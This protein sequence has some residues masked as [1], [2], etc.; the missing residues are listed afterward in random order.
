MLKKVI[1]KNSAINALG[2]AVNYAVQLLLISYLVKNIGGEAYGV[3]VIALALIGNS[4]LLEAGF[5]LS[6]TKYTAECKAKG[7]AEGLDRV[8]NTGF[9]VNTVL[10][11]VFSAAILVVIVF[12]LGFF[13]KVPPEAL[14]AVRVLMLLLLGL[15]FFEFWTVGFI[16]V[17]EGLQNYGLA[18]VMENLKWGLRLIFTAV[19]FVFR[20]D[21]PALGMAYLAAGAV[22]FVV[23]FY[24][25]Y[26]P[27]TGIKFDLSKSNWNIFRKMLGF[28]VWIVISKISSLLLYRINSIL[29][30]IFL[31]PVYAAYYNIGS[32]IYELLRY[33]FSII[34]STLIPVSAEL[35]AK[36]DRRRLAMLFEKSTYYTVLLMAPFIAF[37]VFRSDVLIELWMG[38]AFSPAVSL[39]NLLILSLVPTLLVAS[40]TEILVGLNQLRYLVIYGVAGSVLAF[41]ISLASIKT[42]GINAVAVGAISGSVLIAVG[43]FYRMLH[44]FNFPGTGGY[45]WKTI[46]KLLLPISLLCA[47]LDL[48]DKL[49]PSVVI[50]AAYFTV[51]YILFVEPTEKQHLR[52]FFYRKN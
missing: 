49:S 35:A 36:Q 8:V 17:A 31:A 33:G 37:A 45:K 21:L 44:I 24:F 19:I 25:T 32:K 48:T 18:R 52:S 6:V 47:L 4:N 7:D 20:R 16:R 9:L 12:L 15:S 40:G 5:G 50:L 23:L 10:A 39:A 30:G 28:S 34:S 27:R 1:F 41:I 13:F 46:G 14:P 22:S 29:I 11:G 2:K 38:P 26:G 42:I 43:Y 51:V 3:F